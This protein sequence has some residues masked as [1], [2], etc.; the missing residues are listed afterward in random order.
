MYYKGETHYFV[1]TARKQSLLNK[2]VLKQVSPIHFHLT[3]FTCFL[4]FFKLF[5]LNFLL[6]LLIVTSLKDYEDTSSLISYN[7]VDRE[8]L[9]AYVK[10]AAD[11]S[12]KKQL[13]QLDFAVNQ[14]GQ[15]DVSLFDFTCM[16]V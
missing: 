8:R 15:E 1:M 3:F 7:N 11:F 4:Y 13:P 10:E 16:Y 6:I 12:T 9:T 2:G 5:F 14:Y